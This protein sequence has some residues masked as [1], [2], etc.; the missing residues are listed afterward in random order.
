MNISERLANVNES[1][2]LAMSQKSRE[3]QALGHDVINLSIGQPDFNTPDHIK[4]A[5]KKAID[6]N[7]SKYTP[8]PGLP[9]LRDAVCE[10]FKRDNGLDFSP[11]QIVVSNGAK[12]SIAN[13]ILSLTGPGDEVIIPAPYWVS[14][15]EI[16]NLAQASNVIVE[17]G[18]DQDFKIT[19]EQ[20]EEAIT[21]KTKMFLFSSPS[22]PTGSLYTREELKA[23]AEVF[24][25]YPHVIVV[26]DEIYELITFQG[27]HESIAQFKELQ[28]RV[29]VVNGVSK[30]YAMTGWRIG[31]IAA[32]QWIAD[33]CNKLQGQY[34]SGA[35]SISQMASVAALT[36]TQQP[37]FKMKEVFIRRRDLVVKMA[38]EIKGMKVNIPQ[39]AFYL[40]PEVDYFFGKSC[41]GY[42]INNASDLALYLLETAY[43]ATV[44]GEAFGSPK[45]LRF[46][47]ATSD[48]L[49]MEALKRIK[50]ALDKLE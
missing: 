5:A 35:C 33:A 9:V 8:V 17:A 27:Q 41:N 23:L 10:K 13:V 46:S 3:L 37:S 24:M 26:S 16:V 1:A 28:D 19:P 15:V 34:T 12:Q 2:T 6:D 42:M 30:G 20:L 39:G 31:Y 18:I 14:Y 45:C 50:I 11:S 21:P 36:G 48:E 43:V 29:V 4:E 40:F 49:L 7:V 47:Y 38:K 25:R 32:P 22:N 44:T